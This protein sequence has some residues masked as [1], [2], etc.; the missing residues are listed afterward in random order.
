MRV[1]FGKYA[2]KS[3]EI[4]VLKHPDYAFSILGEREATGHFHDIQVE[5]RR[6]IQLFDQKPILRPCMCGPCMCGRCATRGTVYKRTVQ[7]YWWCENCDP[8]RLGASPGKL[9]I[10]RS[11][12]DAVDCA[13][14]CGAGWRSAFKILINEMAR[15]KGLPERVGEAQ[16]LAFFSGGGHDDNW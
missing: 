11:Y 2:G 16:A 9:Q 8:Y 5:I 13:N 10:I 4:L 15:A 3:T 1:P 14:M 12:F 6:L 7:P